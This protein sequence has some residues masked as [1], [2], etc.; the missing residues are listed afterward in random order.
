[1]EVAVLWILFSFAVAALGDKYERNGFGW[2]LLALAVSPLIAG[3]FLL[4]AGHNGKK[5]PSCAETIKKDAISCRFCHHEF[6]TPKP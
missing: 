1:M 5:C 3:V 2:G 6:S 4:I